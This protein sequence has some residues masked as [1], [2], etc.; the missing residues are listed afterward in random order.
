M[1]AN[2]MILCAALAGV[3]PGAG[4][5]LATIRPKAS[6]I[7][8][9]VATVIE[10]EVG[11]ESY[12]QYF[13]ENDKKISPW[14]DIPISPDGAA[15]DIFNMITEI[16]KMGTAKMEID[17]KTELNPIVQ[18][19]KKGK[20]RFYHGPI[21]WS[22]GCIPQ[23]WEN[24]NEEHPQLKCFGDDDPIDV[25]EIGAEALEAGSVTPVKALG[26]LA[27]IDDGE[28]DW[29]V[30]AIAESDPLFSELN[31]IDDVAAK[32]PGVISGIREWFRWYK[33]PD[34]KPI[35]AFGFDEECLPK[36]KAIEII[37]ETHQAWKGLRDGSID[38]GKLWTGV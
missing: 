33:T 15:E 35:N 17:T 8:R 7:V 32:C 24:P 18:D 20:L 31:D 4:F 21:F 27:M 2:K 1:R 23:T 25:V 37:Q 5:V 11:T 30:I 3:R 19:E 13:V 26:V 38:A 9:S 12:K 22:Y 29:K 10:G 6:G 16:P 36:A 34:G 28:L 14:H